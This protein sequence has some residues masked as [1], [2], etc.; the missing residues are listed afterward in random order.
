VEHPG[1][2]KYGRHHPYGSGARP[3]EEVMAKKTR[4]AEILAIAKRGDRPTSF[5]LERLRRF[6]EERRLNGPDELDG[7]L[8]A[9]IVTLIEVFARS[10]I[11]QLIDHDAPYLERS[12]NLKVEIKYDFAVATSLHGRSISVGQ[13]IAHNV[14]LSDLA[15]IVSVFNIFL[16]DDLWRAISGTK[17][18]SFLAKRSDQGGR[19]YYFQYGQVATISRSAF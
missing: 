17:L 12:A 18:F 1:T 11:E 5:D 19:T 7:L 14:S 4:I 6:W 8:P 2:P 16:D 10:W 15:S 9:R 3:R 13:L